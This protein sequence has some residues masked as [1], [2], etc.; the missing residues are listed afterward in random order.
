MPE[1]PPNHTYLVAGCKPW[2]RRIFDERIRHFPG[3]WQFVSRPEELTP[4]LLQELQAEKV[5]FFHWSWI[6][7]ASILELC[8]C[9]NFHMADVPYGRGGSPLQNLISRGHR[10][11]KLVALRMVSELDAGPVYLRENLSLEGN[12]EEIYIRAT[13][14][15]AKMIQRIIEEGL[16][17]V[18]QEGEALVFKRRSPKESEI[19]QFDS[20]EK[21]YDFLR[22]LDAEGYPAA[23][24]NY[25]GFSFQFRRAALYDG[26]I[27]AD[28]T[29]YQNKDALS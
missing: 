11:T 24:L 28:V 26:R 29:I 18:P 22:M 2:N 12:A 5:F 9:I 19:P 16:Q 4:E 3:N 17:P 7:P 8:E 25:K 27:I 1:L 13:E 15:S 14:L 23:F 6:V 20:L 21:L 10:T